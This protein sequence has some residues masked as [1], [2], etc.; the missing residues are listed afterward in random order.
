MLVIITL[1]HKQMFNVVYK[2]FVSSGRQM[3]LADYLEITPK[4]QK[5]CTNVYEKM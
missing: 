2:I 3:L 5:T 1:N 4:E